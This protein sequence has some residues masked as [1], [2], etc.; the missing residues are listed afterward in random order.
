MCLI[1]TE[2]RISKGATCKNVSRESFAK[3]GILPG[4][5]PP[6][7]NGSDLCIPCGL[8]CDGSLFAHAMLKPGEEA[9]AESLGLQVLRAQTPQPAFALPCH[10]FAG[11]CNRYDQARP[12]V[13]GGF[14]CKLLVKYEQNTL[15]KEE[16]LEIIRRARAMQ[17]SLGGQAPQPSPL[18]LGLA[19]VKKQVQNLATVEERR[20]HLGFITLAAQYEMFLRHHFL[21]Q[22]RKTKAKELPS[23]GE[24]DS[25]A[26]E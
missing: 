3:A 5:N 19:E 25:P 17:A 10:W 18:P 1:I 22:P 24:K 7:P 14:R 16:G 8:C 2:K 26:K 21:W 20:A 11:A 23:M 6:T 12:Q 9:F 4:M 15:E 13:C